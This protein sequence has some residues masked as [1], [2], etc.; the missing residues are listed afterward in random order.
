MSWWSD[1]WVKVQALLEREPDALPKLDWHEPEVSE[2]ELPVVVGALVVWKE[3]ATKHWYMRAR[4][5]DRVGVVEGLKDWGPDSG[6]LAARVNFGGR[7]SIA[8][9]SELIVIPM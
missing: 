2:L 9:A 1:Q 3:S 8:Q 7:R 5:N 4:R 6:G